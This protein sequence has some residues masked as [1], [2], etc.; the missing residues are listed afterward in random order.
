MAGLD[1]MFD[2]RREIEDFTEQRIRKLLEEPLNSFQEPNWV[3]AATLFEEVVIPCKEAYFNKDMYKLANAIVNK[4][5]ENGCEVVY[6]TN[7]E[8]YDLNK[9]ITSSD[10]F[11]ITSHKS[12]I[13]KI[14]DWIQ[15]C[16]DFQK[17]WR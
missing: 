8:V 10:D 15:N 16:K 2:A 17:A 5:K 6:V 13:R 4:A 12:T 9:E 7:P 3:Q 1:E 11:E 14:L